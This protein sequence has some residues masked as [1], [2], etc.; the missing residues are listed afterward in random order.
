[1][2]RSQLLRIVLMIAVLISA[3]IVPSHA[4]DDKYSGTYSAEVIYSEVDGATLSQLGEDFSEDG[5]RKQFEGTFNPFTITKTSAGYE[6]DIQGLISG[7]AEFDGQTVVIRIYLDQMVYFQYDGRYRGDYSSA[8]GTV[9]LIT[10]VGT[11]AKGEWS[12]TRLG[13]LPAV[14]SG[15]TAETD[16]G[17]GSEGD[18]SADT[19]DE[20]EADTEGTD[21]EEVEEEFDLEAFINDDLPEVEAPEITE[22]RPVTMSK[23]DEYRENKKEKVEKV[24]NTLLEIAKEGSMMIDERLGNVV[25][26]IPANREEGWD[27]EQ[28]KHSAKLVGDTF[29]KVA[30]KV[31]GIK[32]LKSTVVSAYE[33]QILTPEDKVKDTQKKY[34]MTQLGAKIYNDQNK[35]DEIEAAFAPVK[36]FVVE[37]TGKVGEYFQ[38][39]L[40][41]MANM[42]RKAL[43]M[44]GSREYKMF[45]AEFARM[46]DAGKS[47]KE[48]LKAASKKVYDHNNSAEVVGETFQNFFKNPIYSLS[49]RI[50]NRESKYPTPKLR[51]GQYISYL[52]EEGLYERGAK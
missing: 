44:A 33:D 45:R 9:N 28:K 1:M 15:D 37:K 16:Q 23:E 11:L 8:S 3:M 10:P 21:A 46:K 12:M 40:D 14:D 5:F 51:C 34:N 50:L 48:A 6:L 39:G 22:F 19:P 43:S 25:K 27:Y 13:D 36:D 24:E 18:A 17:S 49:N 47:Q 26:L 41:K 42:K 35:Y 29:G 52:K 20:G 7:P 32:Y 4:E 31:P 30:E 2:K 38:K